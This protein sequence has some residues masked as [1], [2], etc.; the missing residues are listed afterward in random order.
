M[1]PV[2]LT[3]MLSSAFLG[4]CRLHR[5]TACYFDHLSLHLLLLPF[6]MLIGLAA[7]THV[8][9]PRDMLYTLDPTSLPRDPKSNPQSLSFPLSLNIVLLVTLLLKLSEF[10]SCS[11]T[12]GLFFI[13]LFVFTVTMSMQLANLIQ[14]DGSKY[15]VVDY[16]FIR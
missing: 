7:K 12:W 1:L 3:S 6:L 11:M 2:L 10:A 8:V 14:H 9:P 4:I 16:H 15:I 13:I 5:N